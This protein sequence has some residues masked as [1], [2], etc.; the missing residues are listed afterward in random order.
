MSKDLYYQLGIKQGVAD[1]RC[2][3]KDLISDATFLQW[4]FMVAH[5]TLTVYTSIPAAIPFTE[6]FA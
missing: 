1:N 4:L 2:L 3:F 5:Q 6:D